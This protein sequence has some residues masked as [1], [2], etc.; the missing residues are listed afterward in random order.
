M[1][2]LKMLHLSS[3]RSNAANGQGENMTPP[4][5]P[6]D[7][8]KFWMIMDAT[9]PFR[10]DPERQVAEL[11]QQLR[12]LSTDDLEAFGQA[13]ERAQRNAYRWDLWG[14]AIIINGGA[15]SDGFAYFRNWLI[16]QG[17]DIYEA[18]LADPDSLAAVVSRQDMGHCEF[19]DL[20]FVTDMIWAER[21]IDMPS[22]HARRRLTIGAGESTQAVGSMISEEDAYLR[23]SYPRLWSSM[24]GR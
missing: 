5:R 12:E 1:S 2:V 17:R 9:A 11:G 6:M 22:L 21:R 15:S 7:A 18:A 20:A 16:A 10:R 8:G 19:E 24:V 13:F 23:N 14:A 4:I 3:G